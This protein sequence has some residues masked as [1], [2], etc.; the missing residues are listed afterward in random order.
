MNDPLFL[1]DS[2]I[3]TN[4]R[5]KESDGKYYILQ[6]PTKKSKNKESEIIIDDEFVTVE[7]HRET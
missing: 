6:K 3:Q 2:E 1:L 4:Q 5:N 7:M